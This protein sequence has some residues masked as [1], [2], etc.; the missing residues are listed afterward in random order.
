MQVY[1]GLYPKTVHEQDLASIR[2]KLKQQRKQESDNR[3]FS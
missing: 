3:H 1:V 2:K